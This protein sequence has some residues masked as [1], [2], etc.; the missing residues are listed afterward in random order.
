MGNPFEAPNEFSGQTADVLLA[1]LT[2]PVPLTFQALVRS[3]G[4]FKVTRTRTITSGAGGP[5]GTSSL[6]HFVDA[7]LAR[8]LRLRVVSRLGNVGAGPMYELA[9]D[10]EALA[11]LRQ[12][13]PALLPENLR[14]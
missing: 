12:R 9:M 1:L 4:N 14:G 10:D 5:G 8:L 2:S 3:A 13:Y 11:W 6:G 7:E